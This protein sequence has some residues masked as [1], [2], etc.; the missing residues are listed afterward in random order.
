MSPDHP[1]APLIRELCPKRYPVGWPTVEAEP[2]LDPIEI[3][4]LACALG[5]HGVSVRAAPAEPSEA[6]LDAAVQA[7]PP[8]GLTFSELRTPTRRVLVAALAARDR[9][10]APDAHPEAFCERCGRPNVTWF[11]PSAVWNRAVPKG[12][13]LCPVCFVQSAERAGIRPPAWEVR[14]EVRSVDAPRAELP[15]FVD[16]RGIIWALVDVQQAGR[17]VATPASPPDGLRAAAPDRLAIVL[18]D[19]DAQMRALPSNAGINND[20]RYTFMWEAIN[21]IGGWPDDAIRVAARAALGSAP[22]GTPEDR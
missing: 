1:I 10:G 4:E 16:A 6:M 7:M 9:E 19:F 2:A 5:A 3:Y 8:M 13:I 14:P 12:G 20:V 15:A 11:A 17:R 18:A 21:R 22:R